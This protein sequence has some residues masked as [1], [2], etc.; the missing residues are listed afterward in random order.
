MC[1]DW[2]TFASNMLS[3]EVKHSN[4][5]EHGSGMITISVNEPLPTLEI[6][7]EYVNLF[8]AFSFVLT[9]TPEYHAQ[10]RTYT[11]DFI[12]KNHYLFPPSLCNN[13]LDPSVVSVSDK[14]LAM[15]TILNCHVLVFS[16]YGSE[17]KWSEYRPLIININDIHA[18][19][20]ILIDNSSGEHFIPIV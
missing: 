10:V 17:K 4:G 6:S 12:M 9:G 20:A 19:E 3:L 14:M 11:V 8:S 16:K 5:K 1:K 7:N 15:A 13:F 2:Q 18:H